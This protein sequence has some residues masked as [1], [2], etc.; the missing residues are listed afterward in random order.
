MDNKENSENIT[1]NTKDDFPQIQEIGI[2]T[3][4]INM[5]PERADNIPQDEPPMKSKKKY[6][7]GAVIAVVICAVAIVTAY[8]VINRASTE[9]VDIAKYLEASADPS[10]LVIYRNFEKIDYEAIYR[11]ET[12]YLPMNYIKEYWCDKF[13]YDRESDLVLYTT[14]TEIYKIPF[15]SEKYIDDAGDSIESDAVI[16]FKQD[17]SIYMSVNFLKERS[18]L[19][20]KVFNNPNILAIYEDGTEKQTVKLKENAVV[21]Q[22]ASIKEPILA[23]EAMKLTW[24]EADEGKGT[25]DFKY[26]VSENGIK[27]YVEKDDLEEGTFEKVTFESEYLPLEYRNQLS[28]KPVLLVWHGVYSDA[29]NDSIGSLLESTEGV[30]AVSPTWYKVRNAEGGLE[31]GAVS[32]Y[33]KTVHNMGKEVWPLISDFTS[34]YAEGGWDEKAMLSS[35]KARSEVI[36]RLISDAQVFGFDG[37]NIDFEKVPKDAGE[38]F[39]QFIRELS[40]KCRKRNLVLSIDDY[41][42]REHTMHYNRKAQAECADYVIVMGYDEHYDGCESAGSV[43]S[44]GFVEDGIDKTLLEVPKEKLINAVPF[45]T[46][47]FMEQKDENGKPVLTSKAYTMQGAVD[48]ADEMGLKVK[49]D[50]TALQNVATGE[51]D[52]VIYSVWLEDMESMKTRMT[53]IKK[54]NLA[55]IAAWSLGSEMDKVWSCF[56]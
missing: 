24:F 9:R 50:D 3:I 22:A 51:K 14:D 48:F 28:D 47:L 33:V 43:A 7:I 49:W 35:A 53:M 12:A 2:E 19:I 29:D 8:M 21:R 56:K 13:Y 17:D 27:G 11:N 16:C 41:V 40:I 46:R 1:Q 37:I 39:I 55:G 34:V 4:E 20:Y 31:C 18:K 45:Y 25:D 10:R 36:S 52:G 32:E 54:K 42:P 30:T 44:I 6:I 26:V 15:D 38:D 23:D 5:E